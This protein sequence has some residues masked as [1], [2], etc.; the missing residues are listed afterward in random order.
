[1]KQGNASP[2][3]FQKRMA[4]AI[5]NGQAGHAYCFEGR[6]GS[7][8]WRWTREL[9]LTLLCENPTAETPCGR[10][11][12]CRQASRSEHPDLL[13]IE[14]GQEQERETS[15]D[16]IRRIQERLSLRS[17]TPGGRRVVGIREA[18]LLSDSAANAFLK[19]LEE[20]PA[21]TVMLLTSSRPERMLPTIRSRCQ[22]FLFPNQAV[23][24]V[25]DELRKE[26]P[27]PEPVLQAIARWSGGAS[28]R[29]LAIATQGGE[30][31]LRT[32]RQ[33]LEAPPPLP[34]EMELERLWERL[35]KEHG[36]PARET[37]LLIYEGMLYT[38]HERLRRPP[39]SNADAR[40]ERLLEELL[41]L[42][43]ADRDPF[44][45]KL[46]LEAV[47]EKWDLA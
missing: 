7:G 15:I 35:Q 4:Q 36:T 34:L 14:P 38:L 26:H 3:P 10:C 23:S 2:L 5:R 28:E 45:P 33:W 6:A 31:I 37:A 19:L 22:R 46:L 9:A 44:N 16:Q 21:G 24:R 27:L 1:M 12:P 39:P 29:A 20:P 17:F 42:K 11:G 25:A 47:S 13:L 18:E 43:P 40:T 32:L 30:E 41:S 8:K